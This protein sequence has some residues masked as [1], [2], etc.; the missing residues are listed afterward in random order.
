VSDKYIL[1][2][3]TPVPCND[4]LAWARWFETADRHVGRDQIGPYLVS[5][6][7]LGL[8]HRFG[9]NGPP[10]LFETMTFGADADD[11]DFGFARTATWQEAELAHA[12][13]VEEAQR[14]LT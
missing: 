5:T 12:L 3:K 2:G 1:D 9:R 7:F 10:L 8:D 14:R 13:A 4:L 11:A 6:V